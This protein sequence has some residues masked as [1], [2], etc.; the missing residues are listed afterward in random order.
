M[1]NIYIRARKDSTKKWTKLPFVAT[2]NAIFNVLAACP[3]EWRTPDIAEIVKSAAQKKKYEA[4]LRIAQLAK[5]R[6]KETAASEVRAAWDA[7]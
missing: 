4:N 7:A 1:H 3:S 5:K 6:R 2:N